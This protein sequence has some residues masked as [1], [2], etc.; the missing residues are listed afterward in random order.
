MNNI[1]RKLY[2]NNL[3]AMVVVA[4]LTSGMSVSAKADT[5]LGIYVSATTWS[6]DF[7]GTISDS[8]PSINIEDELDINEDTS[9]LFS[10]AL[11]HPIPFLPNIKLQ[12]T[13]L[14]GV[15]TSVISSDIAFG[16]TNFT[17]GTQVT[18][19]IDL[20][21]TDYILYYEINYMITPIMH[22]IY[23]QFNKKAC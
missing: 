1:I 10:V 14:E 11:E 8:G 6:P 21:H 12:R 23:S 9:T 7:S 18:S 19:Q 16:G 15:G 22:S 17:T 3:L 20:G 4:M 2:T 13:G 5:I